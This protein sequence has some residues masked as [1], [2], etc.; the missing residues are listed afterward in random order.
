MKNCPYTASEVSPLGPESPHCNSTLWGHS[1][2]SC[3][4][5]EWKEIKNRNPMPRGSACLLLWIF[6]S[7]ACPRRRHTGKY[8][9]ANWSWQW[10]VRLSRGLLPLLQH[11]NG[12][13]YQIQVYRLLHPW[14]PVSNSPHLHGKTEVEDSLLLFYQFRIFLTEHKKSQASWC[15]I[16][17]MF[18]I[19][20][21]P[22]L[23]FSDASQ[24][25]SSGF[26]Q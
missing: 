9:P 18:S 20:L 15:Q 1:Q 5:W 3:S 17:A 16:E 10:G 8:E 11:P 25:C 21:T 23:L 14:A 26:K 4:F 24:L 19:T 12:L 7:A 2:L 13:S 6:L 22:Q